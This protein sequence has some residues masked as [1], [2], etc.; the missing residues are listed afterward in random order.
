MVF[1]GMAPSLT[2]V[3]QVNLQAPSK[4]GILPLQIRVGAFPSNTVSIC[5][6]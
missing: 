5:V 2:G 1:A 4:S 3:M 6:R